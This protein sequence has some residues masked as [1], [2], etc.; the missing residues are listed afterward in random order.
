[1]LALLRMLRTQ[2]LTCV[3]ALK[4]SIAFGVEKTYRLQLWLCFT[5]NRTICIVGKRALPDS[6]NA[7][8]PTDPNA[9][10]SANT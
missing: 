1:M 3:R 10:K 8:V 5:M 6:A 4:Q 7:V 2:R 9:E